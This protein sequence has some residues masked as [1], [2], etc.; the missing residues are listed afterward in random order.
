MEKEIQVNSPEDIKE[1]LIDQYLAMSDKQIVKQDTALKMLD[2]KGNLVESLKTEYGGLTVTDYH[3]RDQVEVVRN[4]MRVVREHRAEINKKAKFINGKINEFKKAVK[5][6]SDE[7]VAG[8]DEIYE[9][10][11][12]TRDD[13]ELALR[14]EKEAEEK[15]RMEDWT[16]KAE[17]LLDAG[18]MS[19][20]VQYIAGTVIV[21]AEKLHELTED[22]LVP[23]IQKGIAELERIAEILKDAELMKEVDE[24]AN[25]VMEQATKNKPNIT[26]GFTGNE[27]IEFH[28]L[29]NAT[30]ADSP[31]IPDAPFDAPEKGFDA[32]NL[33][34]DT[35]NLKKTVTAELQQIPEGFLM[36]WNAFKYE[37]I[38]LLETTEPMTRPGL[39]EIIR[40]LEPKN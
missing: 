40:E 15:A 39:I 17:M 3:D 13:A 2:P 29:P 37:V 26:I 11:L 16:R 20:G 30:P 18:F 22:D 12:K 1:S 5:D 23:I 7:L 8:L 33:Q 28:N 4:A 35:L 14:S 21:D 19:N 27:K 6:K 10:L 32:L 24:F 25:A 34:K 36:G 9:P 38:D 31:A